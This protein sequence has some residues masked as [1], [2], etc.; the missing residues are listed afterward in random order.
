MPGNRSRARRGCRDRSGHRGRRC[1]RR[2]RRAGRAA[3][4]PRRR[5]GDR[6]GKP[7]GGLPGGGGPFRRAGGG[8][9]GALVALL[10][11]SVISGVVRGAVTRPQ[12]ASAA[13]QVA[14]VVVAAAILAAL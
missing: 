10:S 11:F 1:A 5:D 9:L 2:G 4:G 7:G 12:G 13:A 14:Y 8:G 3:G 6:R